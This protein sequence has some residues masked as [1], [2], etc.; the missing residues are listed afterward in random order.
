VTSPQ[1]VFLAREGFHGTVLF[2]LVGSALALLVCIPIAMIDVGLAHG[3][4]YRVEADPIRLDAVTADGRPI[5]VVHT[6]ADDA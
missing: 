6:E 1:A 4:R 2:A 3:Q 5:T